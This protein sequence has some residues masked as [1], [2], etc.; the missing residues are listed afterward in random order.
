LQSEPPLPQDAS[1]PIKET[2]FQP[3]VKAIPNRLKE[4]TTPTGNHD[5]HPRVDIIKPSLVSPVALQPTY[6]SQHN[7]PPEHRYP[8]RLRVAKAATSVQLEQTQ[9]NNPK[10]V[11]YQHLTDIVNPPSLLKYKQLIKTADK[12]IWKKAMCNELGRLSQGYKDVKGKTPFSSFRE[13]KFQA[14]KR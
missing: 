7:A 13:T 10:P 14:T 4:S 8:T 2:N 11:S 9:I 5:A 3:R 12:E 1:P 6:M